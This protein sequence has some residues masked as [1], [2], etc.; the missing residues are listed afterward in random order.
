M[1]SDSVPND[2]S[3]GQG[4]NHGIA[5]AVNI[6]NLLAA[7]KPD[8]KTQEAAIEEYIEELIVRAGEETKLSVVSADMLHDWE[9]FIDSQIMKYGGHAVN[10][11]KVTLEEQR[12]KVELLE[13]EGRLRNGRG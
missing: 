12:L 9:R 11:N 3:T 7:M 1:C 10:T 4:Q 2:I 6:T 8:N 5:D 13:K